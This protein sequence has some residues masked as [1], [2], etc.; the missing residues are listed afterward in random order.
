MNVPTI[1]PNLDRSSLNQP[2]FGINPGS[3]FPSN[4]GQPPPTTKSNPTLVYPMRV[5]PQALAIQRNWDVGVP[6]FVMKTVSV[7]A[8]DA[9]DLPTLRWMIGESK[10][11][12]LETKYG[13]SNEADYGYGSRGGGGSNKRAKI[14]TDDTFVDLD[15]FARKFAFCGVLIGRPTAE[16]PS[17]RYAGP[18]VPATGPLLAPLAYEG[19]VLIPNLFESTTP[20]GMGQKLYL[21]VKPI[22]LSKAGPH[23]NPQGESCAT[24][25]RATADLSQETMIE[26][27]FYTTPDNTPPPRLTPDE[28]NDLYH[29]VDKQPR[30]TCRQYKKFDSKN[31]NMFTFEDGLVFELGWSL[32]K[33][34]ATSSIHQDNLTCVKTYTNDEINQKSKME[35][36]LKINQIFS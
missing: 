19:K 4:V 22:P 24:F 1:Y 10:K 20:I 26:F 35:V 16:T 5:K 13:N 11:L 12:H 29:N 14:I 32:F 23:N 3:S 31:R 34:E 8:Q 33:Y 25:K 15:L 9:Y 6:I 2:E 17:S 27:I 21:L 30:L 18:N 28:R 36:I 7:T